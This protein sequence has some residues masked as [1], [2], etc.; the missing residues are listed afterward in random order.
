MQKS[1]QH[2][3]VLQQQGGMENST[4]DFRAKPANLLITRKRS[5]ETLPE[6]NSSPLKIDPWK[7][8]FLLE[9]TIFRGYVSFR[10][11]KSADFNVGIQTTC[12]ELPPECFF[13]QGVYR[14]IHVL[15]FDSQQ[16]QGSGIWLFL[17]RIHFEGMPHSKCPGQCIQ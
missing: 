13:R 16:Y 7:R 14:Q 11:C 6:T 3:Q 2:L 10:E 1:S 12:T 17:S 4:I 5:Q 15:L 9:S 8:R